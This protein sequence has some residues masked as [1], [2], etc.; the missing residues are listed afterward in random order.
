MFMMLKNFFSRMMGAFLVS[1]VLLNSSAFAEDVLPKSFS[2][3]ALE[4]E[5]YVAIDYL[6]T[7]NIVKGYDDGTFKSENKINRAEFLKIVLEA[8]ENLN[9]AALEVAPHDGLTNC[10]KDVKD[11]WFATYVCVASKE[12]IVKGYAD[13]YFRP[14]KEINFVEAAKIVANVLELQVGKEAADNWYKPYVDALDGESAIPKSISGFDHKLTRGEM[15]ELVWRIK[16][17]PDY[18]GSLSYTGLERRVRAAEDDYALQKFDSCVDLGDYI[19]ENTEVYQ[20]YPYDDEVM[21]MKSV[22]AVE[23]DSGDDDSGG[24]VTA[25]E[26]PSDGLGGGSPEA[27]AMD[28]VSYS[29]TNVQVEGVDE[30]DIVKT[31]GK[32]IYVLK[33]NTVRVLNA[34]PASEMTELDRVSFTSE[35]F[36]PSDMYVDANRLIVIGTLYSGIE[37]VFDDFGVDESAKMSKFAPPSYYYGGTTQIN[38]FDISDKTNIKPFRELAFEGEY[39]NSRKVDDMVYLVMN[40][41]GYNTVPEQFTDETVVPRYVDSQQGDIKPLTTCDDVYYFPGVESTDYLQVV[42]VPVDTADAKVSKEV[43]VGGGENIYASREHLYV[44]QS[45]YDWYWASSDNKAETVV[46]KFRLGRDAITYL[47]KGSVPGDIVNQFSMDEY[48]EHFRIATTVGNVWDEDNLSKNNVY[49]LDKEMKQV[50]SLEGIAPGEKIYSVR[51]MGNKAYVVTFKKVDPLF[52]ID[53]GDP[54]NPKILGQLKIPGY[55]DYL[56]PF[57]EN[58]IIGFGKDAVEASEDEKVEWDQNFAW[59]QGMKVAMFDVT[60][61]TNPTQLHQIVIGDRGTESPLL[62]DHKALMFDKARGIMAFPVTEAQIPEDK[63]AEA[64]D[65]TYGDYVFQGAYVYKVSI[66]KGFEYSGRITHYHEDEVKDKS[67]YYWSGEQDIERILYIGDYL[68]TVSQAAVLASQISDLSTVKRVDLA[69]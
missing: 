45:K 10:F 37:T 12:G 42:G 48:K 53:V 8:S 57:D 33:G 26:P 61:V 14:E 11:Q 29:S 41:Y 60:D 2:D 30:A 56:H 66:D 38:I 54:A 59:Y 36:Y 63:K 6:R 55:S 67:G 16:E 69:E 43:V 58:H 19:E 51:F 52:V 24:A 46:N 22:D 3:V 34:Y 9:S 31:D 62:Y 39:S 20:N 32:Y 64:E 18:V 13:G 1:A 40:K 27:P 4:D 7:N 49:I 50:G 17:K 65:N 21:M 68:Y 47:G 44:A 5:N 28:D 15:A 23:E 35:D 25:A